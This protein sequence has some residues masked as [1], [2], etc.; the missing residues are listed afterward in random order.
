ML[1]YPEHINTDNYWY[2]DWQNMPLNK[3]VLQISDG[4]EDTH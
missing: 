1:S 3:E 4:R 2:N